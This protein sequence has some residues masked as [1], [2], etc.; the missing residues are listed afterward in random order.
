MEKNNEEKKMQ[1]INNYFLIT[2]DN[3]FKIMD[4]MHLALVNDHFQKALGILEEN[5]FGNFFQIFFNKIFPIKTNSDLFFQN[6]FLVEKFFMQNNIKEIKD[7][8][9]SMNYM[10]NFDY[11][12][13]FF[14]SKEM[15]EHIGNILIFGFAKIK[16]KFK[17]YLI[18]SYADFKEKIESIKFHQIDLLNEYYNQEFFQKKSKG[19]NKNIKKYLY[20]TDPFVDNEGKV[21]GKESKLLPNELILLINKLQYIKTISFQIENIF[22]DSE[23]NNNN[24]MDSEMIK[25]LIIL[26]NIQWL[27]PN[28][29]VINFN[30]SN[31][32]LSNALIEIM[33]LKLSLENKSLN[34]YDKKTY[35][36]FNKIPL[37]NNDN[38]DLIIKSQKNLIDNN[39]IYF[40]EKNIDLEIEDSDEDNLQLKERKEKLNEI[41]KNYIN[42]YSKIFDLII[43]TTYYIRIM[44]KLHA[45]HIQCPDVFCAEI[46]ECYSNFQNPK[47]I[48]FLNLL[49]DVK[50]LNILNI[51]FNCLDFTN[52][53]KILG[54]INS[55]INLSSLKLIFFSCEKV[56]SS[57]GIYKLIND[58]NVPQ[59][60]INLLLDNCTNFEQGI[61]NKFLL[62]KFQKNLEILSTLIKNRKKT[63]N[64]LCLV[65]NIPSLL[66]NNDNYILS[67]IKFIINIFIFL[68]SE[69]NQIKIF[70]LIAPLIKLDNR[71]TIFLNN[72]FSK[73]QKNFSENIQTLYL[74]L[75]FCKINTIVNLIKTNL[76][77][78][79]I[80]N[81]DIDTFSSFVD[82]FTSDEFIKESKLVNIKIILNKGIIEYDNELKKNFLK[83]FQKNPKNLMNLEIITNIKINYEQLHELII[84]IKKNYVNKYFITFNKES[85][86]VID[87]ITNK[88]IPYVISLNKLDEENLKIIAK[89]ILEKTKK[90][91]GD[92]KKI[93]ELRKK[94]F[95]NI[96]IMIFD[97]KD[98]KLDYV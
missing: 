71:K 56:Y 96:K 6:N 58:I 85:K 90:G 7:I 76:I 20:F 9:E 65:L 67:L 79:N 18:K 95:N 27:L 19:K 28:I 31:P 88:E 46:R 51:E 41:Y 97:K 84:L 35:S 44:D 50:Q 13:E 82:K 38:Y 23:I 24:N 2:S 55:N 26:I 22:N 8:S 25:Y 72:F 43:V 68:C 81:L 86:I 73:I 64:E 61:L 12:S 4:N 49:I 66:S 1:K 10:L 53:E 15:I 36:P 5:A 54:I 83:L 33:S 93:F 89:I 74:Q 3:R 59:F 30:L 47:D 40:K 37:F 60:N 14:L 91:N 16:N 57:G 70:K 42:K 29:L 45:L 87:E 75:N 69:K 11:K 94:I 32:N 80:G 48:N 21:L 63:L 34:I 52:F 98:I 77:N 78:L 39:I 17:L 62:E 92:C